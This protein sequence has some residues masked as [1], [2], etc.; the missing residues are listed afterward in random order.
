M[1]LL[2]I[3]IAGALWIISFVFLLLFEF[4]PLGVEEFERKI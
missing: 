4:G 1:S 2:E 3:I